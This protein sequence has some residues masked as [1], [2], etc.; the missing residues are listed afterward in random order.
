MF[1]AHK[2]FLNRSK[3]LPG[4]SND[5]LEHERRSAII[6]P[7]PRFLEGQINRW[8]NEGGALGSREIGFQELSRRTGPVDNVLLL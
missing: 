5:V 8:T 2:F 6:N 1:D 4:P 3:R 7:D